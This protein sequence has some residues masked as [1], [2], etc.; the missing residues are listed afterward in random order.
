MK[1]KNKNTEVS[2]ETT[3]FVGKMTCKKFVKFV[4]K[5]GSVENVQ[6]NV[7]Q[8]RNTSVIGLF[9]SSDRSW[10]DVYKKHW[11][12]YTKKYNIQIELP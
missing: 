4:C 7:D 10:Y 11:I 9:G 8:F 5:M 1:K 6:F 12:K 3:H 2:S